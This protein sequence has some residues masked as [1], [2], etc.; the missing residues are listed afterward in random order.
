MNQPIDP[1]AV[2]AALAFLQQQQNGKTSGQK[3][4]KA[5]KQQAKKQDPAMQGLLWFAAIVLLTVIAL[6]LID[7]FNKQILPLLTANGFS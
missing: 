7:I 1:K 6:Q 4:K 2:A 3:G 5:K